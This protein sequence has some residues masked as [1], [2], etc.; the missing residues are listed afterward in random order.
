METFFEVHTFH[1][2]KIAKKVEQAR[3]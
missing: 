2:I 3:R 1:Y